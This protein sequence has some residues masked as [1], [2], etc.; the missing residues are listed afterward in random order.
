MIRAN[1]KS[2]A[3]ILVWGTLLP[4]CFFWLMAAWR[5][6]RQR[7]EDMARR[8]ICRLCWLEFEAENSVNTCPQ[9]GARTAAEQPAA[10]RAGCVEG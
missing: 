6:M 9:C 1:W 3:A 4:V 5:Q 8:I 10:G 7:R 2:L